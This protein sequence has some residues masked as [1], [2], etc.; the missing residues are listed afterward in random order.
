MVNNIMSGN[1][2]GLVRL[3]EMSASLFTLGFC[4]LGIL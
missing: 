2:V 4:V 3:G 1:E